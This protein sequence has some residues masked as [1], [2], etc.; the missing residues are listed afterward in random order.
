[1]QDAV[2]SD[3]VNADA[4][5][6]HSRVDVGVSDRLGAEGG[7]SADQDVPMSVAMAKSA[8]VAMLRSAFLAR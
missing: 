3:A 6:P 2:P 1:M 5:S 7:S 8:V 4:E